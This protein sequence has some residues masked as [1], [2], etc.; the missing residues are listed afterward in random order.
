MRKQR[1][2][3]KA[4]RGAIIIELYK[5]NTMGFVERGFVLNI[6]QDTIG[7]TYKY[8]AVRKTILDW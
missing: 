1:S 2:L 6:P 3:S 7:M 5:Y 4:T 8:I